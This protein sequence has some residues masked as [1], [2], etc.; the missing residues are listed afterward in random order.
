MI[1]YI[2]TNYDK[3]FVK[4]NARGEPGL[5]YVKVGEG[6]VIYYVEAVTTQY[7]NRKLLVNKQMVKAG[8]NYIPKLNGLEKSITKKE[9]ESQ[10]LTD[11]R[12]IREAYV[13]DVKE[14]HSTTIVPENSEKSNISDK[15]IL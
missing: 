8:I 9:S 4:Q 15:K 10:Y 14:N 12:K 13:Q 2:V 5:V 1:P 7:H 6:N 11:L 3:V